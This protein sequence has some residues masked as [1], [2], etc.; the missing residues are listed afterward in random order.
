MPQQA[1]GAMDPDRQDSCRALP[2]CA[3]LVAVPGASSGPAR[4]AASEGRLKCDVPSVPSLV[5]SLFPVW[6]NE[7]FGF[8]VFRISATT[9]MDAVVSLWPYFQP[10]GTLGT[11]G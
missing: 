3:R 2:A 4:M 6:L 1:A 9:H 10:P 8:P 5:P 11:L 7:F